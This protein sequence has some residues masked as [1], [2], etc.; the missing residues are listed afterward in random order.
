MFT[1]VF[2]CV[3]IVYYVNNLFMNILGLINTC[4]LHLSYR[5]AKR[6]VFIEDESPRPTGSDS[7]I[8]QCLLQELVWP[9]TSLIFLVT[10]MT[11]IR[12][13]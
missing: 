7:S 12:P 13:R 3:N 2:L 11:W 4:I 5:D 8:P 6:D 1:V 9:L 10:I